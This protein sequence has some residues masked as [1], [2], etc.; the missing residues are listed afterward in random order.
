MADT[1]QWAN[2]ASRRANLCYQKSAAA[3]SKVDGYAQTFQMKLENGQTSVGSVMGFFCSI[4]T[5]L[6][7][8]GFAYTKA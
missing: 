1:N 2:Q 8:L 6:A 7:C 3:V 4:L 5:T